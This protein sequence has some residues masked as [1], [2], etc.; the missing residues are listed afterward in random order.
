M[1]L[2]H[3]DGGV[4]RACNGGVSGYGRAAW[5]ATV[6]RASVR[7]ASGVRTPRPAL[8]R[9]PGGFGSARERGRRCGLLQRMT[10]RLATALGTLLSLDRL[11]DDISAQLAVALASASLP[12][13]LFA[14]QEDGFG[15]AMDLGCFGRWPPDW[16]DHGLTERC[17]APARPA[18]TTASA[19]GEGRDWGTS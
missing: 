1:L 8:A 2:H 10:L 5:P 19:A 17:A 15:G 6:P 3:R 18:G 12:Q 9:E 14:R 11:A 16:T 13:T 7:H 4:S